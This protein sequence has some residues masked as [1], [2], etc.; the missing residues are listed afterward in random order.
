MPLFS[1]TTSHIKILFQTE[2]P[3]LYRM[4]LS[5]PIDIYR[6]KLTLSIEVSKENVDAI[7]TE[8]RTP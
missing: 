7:Q 8:V 2:E 3:T 6:G 1:T 4:S 5:I